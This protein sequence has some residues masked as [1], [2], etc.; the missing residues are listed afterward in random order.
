[1]RK[2]PCRHCAGLGFL[3]FSA[4]TLLACDCA[5]ADDWAKA[6][7]LVWGECWSC[8]GEG[9]EGSFCIDDLCHGGEVPC[10]HGDQD[11]IRCDWCGGRGGYWIT[12]D[13]Y[14]RAEVARG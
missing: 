8:H 12:E 14:W 7:G 5:A 10:M 2:R 4:D 9:G 3:D 11:L 6:V 1:M 13:A